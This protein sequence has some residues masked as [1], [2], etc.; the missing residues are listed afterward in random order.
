MAQDLTQNLGLLKAIV[1]GLS[2]AILLC[3]AIMTAYII[4]T[5]TGG[6]DAPANVVANLPAG[7]QIV[8]M[9]TQ[10]GT[11]LVRIQGPEGDQVLSF[12]LATGQRTG[13]LRFVPAP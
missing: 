9:D 13:T 6:P 1:I 5:V 10:D 8:E 11:L 12:D 2:V 7:A 3:L 4:S